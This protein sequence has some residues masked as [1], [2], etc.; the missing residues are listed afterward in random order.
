[1][2]G[3]MVLWNAG[4][5]GR[6]LAGLSGRGPAV[7]SIEKPFERNLNWFTGVLAHCVGLC[8]CVCV[9]LCPGLHAPVCV[10]V[11]GGEF[12]IHSLS[13]I[14]RITMNADKRH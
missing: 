6:G 5:S 11:W 3:W 1:M 2:D 14:E 12:T 7:L 8:V 9:C 10:C 4:M 13:R